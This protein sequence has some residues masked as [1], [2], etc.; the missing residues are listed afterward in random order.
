MLQHVLTGHRV[1]CL[2]STVRLAWFVGEVSSDLTP[3]VNDPAAGESL[4]AMRDGKWRKARDA[5]KALCKQDRTRYLPLLVESNA[6]LAQEMISKGLLKDAETVIDYLATIAPPELVAK[7]RAT[8]AAPTLSAAGRSDGGGAIQ[9]AV[10]LLAAVGAAAGNAISPEDMAA[11]DALVTDGFSPPEGI[12]ETANQLAAELAAVRTASAATGDGRWDEAKEALRALP[13]DSVFSHWRMFLRGARH[14]F[15]EEREMARKCFADLPPEGAL[16]RAARTLDPELPSRGPTAPVRARVPFF[17]AATGQPTAWGNAIL[18]AETAGKSGKATPAYRILNK[19]LKGAFPD[20]RPGLAALLTEGVLPFS[21]NLSEDD[22]HDGFDLLEDLAY[23][24]GPDSRNFLLTVVRESCLAYPEDNAPGEL[25]RSWA[26]VLREFSRRDGA[27]PQRD[28]VGW[29]WLGETLAN[30][31]EMEDD[32]WDS[33][34]DLGH[35]RKALEKSVEADPECHE[36]WLSLLHVLEKSGDAKEHNRLLGELVKRFP[37]NKK[38]LLHAGNEALARKT[39]TKALKSLR[40][41]LELDPLDRNIKYSIAIALVRQA[42]DLRK[43]KKPTTAVWEALEPLLEDRPSTA[44][45]MLSRW[46]ARLRTGLLETDKTVA[47]LA[48][49]DAEKL[50]PSALERLFLEENLRDAYRLPQPKSLA[51][52]WHA[53]V[54]KEPPSWEEFARI[55]P[56]ADFTGAILPWGATTWDRAVKRLGMT[57]AAMVCNASDKDLAGLADF[58][59]GT[60]R[61]RKGLSRD[62]DDLFPLTLRRILNEIEAIKTPKLKP[63]PW[64]QLAILLALEASGRVQTLSPTTFFKRLNLII[65]Q[66]EKSGD[67][68]LVA[69][70]R[71]LDARVKCRFQAPDSD[72]FYDPDDSYDPFDS[73]DPGQEKLPPSL[74][75]MLADAMKSM[76]E[77]AQKVHGGSGKSGRNS[78][79]KRRGGSNPFDFFP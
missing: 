51:L 9:W 79:S 24:N 52:D 60:E 16:A 69:K 40:A 21:R 14:V 27:D 31:E 43:K 23:A 58:L 25:E 30:S 26:A 78:A 36:A 18:D 29:Q 50:A 65:T 68:A 2:K 37:H 34:P 74:M 70:A 35:A 17:L 22:F 38:I 5:A 48:M 57:V 6:G 12:D 20:D 66:A 73:F 62:I 61:L 75:D 53:Q 55:F 41:A 49:A 67:S 39:Y 44:Y 72:E 4:R 11:I 8:L 3:F 64:L 28:A 77:E 59:E 56:L 1:L 47:E 19:A 10:A 54:L 46:I 13:R 45:F 42:L 71:A 32:D 76:A 33:R 63:R 7:L 15:A